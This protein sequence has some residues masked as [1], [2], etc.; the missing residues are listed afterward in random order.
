MEKI[1]FPFTLCV[2]FIIFSLMLSAEVAADTTVSI[3]N[4]ISAPARMVTLN[5]SVTEEFFNGF[6]FDVFYDE[7]VLI[8]RIVQEGEFGGCFFADPHNTINGENIIS[9]MADYSTNKSFSGTLFS[10]T[11]E[12]LGDYEE[13]S[14]VGFYGED[15]KLTMENGNELTLTLLPGSV[16]VICPKYGDVNLNNS[17]TI[18]DVI[19]VLRYIVG[20]IELSEEQLI[21]AKVSDQDSSINIGDAIL[22]LRYV[23]GL[24]SQFPTEKFLVELPEGLKENEFDFEAEVAQNEALGEALYNDGDGERVFIPD[25]P[26]DSYYHKEE[27]I[28]NPDEIIFYEINTFDNDNLTYFYNHNDGGMPESLGANTVQDFEKFLIKPASEPP[29]MI[30]RINFPGAQFKD[31]DGNYSRGTISI[32]GNVV[33]AGD[34]RFD[35]GEPHENLNSATYSDHAIKMW[36]HT[37]LMFDPM[38]PDC[39]PNSEDVYNGWVF[40]KN[41]SR[42]TSCFITDEFVSEFYEIGI[43]HGWEWQCPDGPLE[44]VLTVSFVY[45]RNVYGE[46]PSRDSQQALYVLR[47]AA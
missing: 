8:P 20:L 19:L 1:F 24:I 3:E 4:K 21:N 25:Y 45:S 43:Q 16:T 29:P 44:R 35:F 15:N 46:T 23:V 27:T 12:V 39:G 10:I 30:S 14:N 7:S 34:Y 42:M 6:Q 41:Y 38:P 26:H 28:E 33:I 40:N 47:E 36:E 22:I 37:P 13:V 32:Q 2:T 5:A 9:I 18:S 31:G 17:I 11:F